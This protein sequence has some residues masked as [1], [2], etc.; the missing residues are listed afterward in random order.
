MTVNDSSTSKDKSVTWLLEEAYIPNL[1]PLSWGAGLQM[2]ATFPLTYGH[3]PIMLPSS[4]PHPVT[5]SFLKDVVTYV[6]KGEKNGLYT[7]PDVLRELAKEPES[8]DMFRTYDWVR[9]RRTYHVYEEE[10]TL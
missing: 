4:V 3:T 6:P 10:L 1:L 2:T 8:L 5:A 9:L 7:T